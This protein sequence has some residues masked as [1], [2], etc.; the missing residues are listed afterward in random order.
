M[1]QYTGDPV[2]GTGATIRCRADRHACTVVQVISP[3]RIAVRRDRAIREDV[4]G[5]SGRQDY[6]Y[7][8]DPSAA[9]EL[10]SLC[11]GQWV[12]EGNPENVLTL[13]ARDEY[14]DFS[15]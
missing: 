6:C 8:T 13:G 3:R 15:L 1:P 7:V 4:N 5:A 9:E 12:Q 11:G 14:Y 2:S 10:F